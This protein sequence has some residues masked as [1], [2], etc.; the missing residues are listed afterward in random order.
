MLIA[1]MSPELSKCIE[2]MAKAGGEDAVQP[3]HERHRT[4]TRTQPGSPSRSRINTGHGQRASLEAN[5]LESSARTNDNPIFSTLLNITGASASRR[6]LGGPP[7][8]LCPP[9][10]SP[11]M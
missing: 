7:F 11:R 6:T 5:K 2:E 10:M 9:N 3:V 8:R 1:R 4:V